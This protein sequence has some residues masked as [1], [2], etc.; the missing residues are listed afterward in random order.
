MLPAAGDSPEGAAAVFGDDEGAV[1]GDGDSDGASPDLFVGDDKAGHEVFVL[2]GGFA[3]W[4]E[5]EA[6]D[7]VA[8]AA[9]AVPGAVEGDERV[10]AVLGGEHR[11]VVEGDLEGGGVGL[12][13]DVGEG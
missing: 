2:A 11:T 4:V 8:G 10:A 5:A 12:D 7:L 6:D 3:G 13:E 1:F 9:R